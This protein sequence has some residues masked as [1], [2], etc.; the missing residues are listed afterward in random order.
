MTAC[1][2]LVGSHIVEHPAAHLKCGHCQRVV[3]K[4]TAEIRRFPGIDV[5][6]CHDCQFERLTAEL[7]DEVASSAGC[8]RS[9]EE[10]QKFGSARERTR[11]LL[12]GVT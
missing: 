5:V 9:A 2:H 12:R 6:C 3:S 11:I 4:A 1:S 8:G 7:L 10:A